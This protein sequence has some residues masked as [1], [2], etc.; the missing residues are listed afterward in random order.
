MNTT[1]HHP[2]V[3]HSESTAFVL[4]CHIHITLNLGHHRKYR[5]R[6]TIT[7]DRDKARAVTSS[8]NKKIAAA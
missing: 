2:F 8:I 1:I 5:E 3:C 6:H 7:H 4:M